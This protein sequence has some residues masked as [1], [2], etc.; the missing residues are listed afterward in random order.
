MAA[1]RAWLPAIA[2]L[3]WC[4]AAGAIQQV[5]SLY[6]AIDLSLCEAVAGGGRLC[7]G[8]PGYP[9]YVT[10]GAQKAY[11]SVGAD[12]GSRLA[13]RQTLGSRNTLFDKGGQRTTVEWR[14]IVRDG[15]PVPYA[16]IVRYFT[17]DEGGHGEVLV[18][19]RVT[20]REACHVAYVDALANADAIVLARKLADTVARSEACPAA[21]SAHGT[22]GFS[23]M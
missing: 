1:S 22:Q 12:A 16:T 3:C 23:P 8:L 10:E 14:F 7:K 13:A 6:T 20:D 19:M 18:V 15:T 21:P 4:G 2:V 11:L 5:K 17:R 9:V